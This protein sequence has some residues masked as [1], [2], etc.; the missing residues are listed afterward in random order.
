MACNCLC[1]VNHPD[2]RGICTGEHDRIVV[3]EVNA[4]ESPVHGLIGVPMCAPCANAS[5]LHKDLK[6]RNGT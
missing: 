5:F 3:F 4:P 1:V 2:E 6:E